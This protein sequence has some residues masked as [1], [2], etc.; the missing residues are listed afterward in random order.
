MD[1]SFISH[2]SGNKKNPQYITHLIVYGSLCYVCISTFKWMGYSLA[3]CAK[4]HNTNIF[5]P[6]QIMHLLSFVLF[7]FIIYCIFCIFWGILVVEDV[8][9]NIYLLHAFC[10]DMGL[11]SFCL[12]YVVYS[13][14]CQFICFHAGNMHYWESSYL[15]TLVSLYS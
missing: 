11:F 6:F 8:L 15:Y 7:C 5:F 2:K 4:E 1:V 12:F 9:Y 3:F 13:I 14:C 10:F